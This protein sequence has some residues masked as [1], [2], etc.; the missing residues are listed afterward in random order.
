MREIQIL[1]ACA[2][3]FEVVQM[4]LKNGLRLIWNDTKIFISQA[5]QKTLQTLRF[6]QNRRWYSRN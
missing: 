5:K 1:Q 4:L 2:L 6:S 3:F